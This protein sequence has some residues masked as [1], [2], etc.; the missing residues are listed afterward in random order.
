[1]V[2]DKFSVSAFFEVSSFFEVR[3]GLRDR[4]RGIFFSSG[5]RNLT[6]FIDFSEKKI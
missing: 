1:M 6:N 5:F 3:S 2:S 4:L